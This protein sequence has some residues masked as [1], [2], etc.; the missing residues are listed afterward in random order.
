M[1]EDR[2]KRVVEALAKDAMQRN[3]SGPSPELYWDECGIEQKVERVRDSLL[4]MEHLLEVMSKR[5]GEALKVAKLH[6]HGRRRCTE[7]RSPGRCASADAVSLQG[8]DP[9]GQAR[10]PRDLD[11]G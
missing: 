1:D 11:R 4:R 5:A 8:D 3:E 2:G 7:R 9:G 6:Y 10:H